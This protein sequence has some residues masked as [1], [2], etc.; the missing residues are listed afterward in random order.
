MRLCNEVQ[1]EF[2]FYIIGHGVVGSIHEV[3]DQYR[4]NPIEWWNIYSGSTTHL[5]KLVVRVLSLVVNTSTIESCWSTSDF[6]L[7]VTTNV[8]NVDQV[9]SDNELSHYCEATMNDNI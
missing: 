9:E 5:H 4:M 8:L 6:T 3:K 2:Q 7:N 1:R